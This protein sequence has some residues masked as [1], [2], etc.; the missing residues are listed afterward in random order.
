MFPGAFCSVRFAGIMLDSN[1]TRWL[2]ILLTLSVVQSFT[3]KS[4]LARNIPSLAG[5]RLFASPSTT[6]VLVDGTLVG[7][8]S[9]GRVHLCTIGEETVIGK[10]AYILEE[11]EKVSALKDPQHRLKR[12]DYYFNVERHCFEKMARH[13]QLPVYRGIVKDKA[14]NSWM[15]FD[16]IESLS[17]Q[18]APTLQQVMEA[19]W[20][21]QHESESH[22]LSKLEEALEL[23]DASF[24]DTLDC[25]VES[26]LEVLTFVHEQRIVHRDVK[27]GNL[28]IANKKLHL[29]D[30]GSAADMDPQRHGI[31]GRTRVGLENENLVAC[32]PVYS[33]PELFVR[34]DRYVVIK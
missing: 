29:I 15:T 27:P 20:K 9:Y 24:G 4:P 5:S 8:G 23:T 12:C 18:C 10:R 33:A 1:M 3:R 22:H 19:D 7:R 16:P 21:S 31:W 6:S 26:L 14:G 34:P 25:V 28:I 13:P 30:F 2:S 17:N 32:S 11:L